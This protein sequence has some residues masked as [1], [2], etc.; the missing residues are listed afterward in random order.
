MRIKQS[1]IK[2]VKMSSLC[3]DFRLRSILYCLGQHS[4]DV[5]YFYLKEIV[6]ST[7]TLVSFQ[8]VTNP[9]AQK[10]DTDYDDNSI[11]TRSV[12]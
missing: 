1:T 3:K 5:F 9:R 4:S 11:H 10:H 2:T 7:L 12:M 6:I 8:K